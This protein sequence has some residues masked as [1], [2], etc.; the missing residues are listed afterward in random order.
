MDRHEPQVHTNS[1]PRESDAK[2]LTN[3]ASRAGNILRLGGNKLTAAAVAGLLTIT[4]A[5]CG[6]NANAEGPKP[7][8]TTSAEATPTP[9]ATGPKVYTDDELIAM[10]N[11]ALP[12]NLSQYES[13]AVADFEALPIEERLSYCSYLNRDQ[14]YLAG[15]WFKAYDE[16]ARYLVP[17]N[18][19]EDSTAQE[20]I[21]QSGY[22]MSN[23]FVTHFGGKIY[24]RDTAQKQIACGYYT[25]SADTPG[26]TYWTDL[27]NQPYDIVP[28]ALVADQEGLQMTT[29]VGE[30]P[31][32]TIT[33]D[34]G[35]E[36]F[37]RDITSQ[38]SSG[39]TF[40]ATHILVPY[41]DYKG[42]A[43][44]TYVQYAQ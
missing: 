30:K 44:S 43:R 14:D 20:I 24:D 17:E 1:S 12:A 10:E 37:A 15:E 8:T 7:T 19:D 34:D 42:N 5:G 22:D 38:D 9:E 25:A 40:D 28:P 13:M 21:S 4:L 3:F 2:E 32:Y 29:A 11:E 41:T 23:A 31:S 35:K 36:Y 6:A 33:T 26:Y 27:R 39:N 18:L 16:D